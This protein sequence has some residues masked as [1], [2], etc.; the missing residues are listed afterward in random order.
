MGKSWLTTLGGVL[1]AAGASLILSEDHIVRV[2]GQILSVVGPLL[3][4]WAAKQYNVTGGSIPQPTPPGVAVQSDL[5]GVVA[6]V[7]AM[8]KPSYDELRLKKMAKEILAEPPP[9]PAA[10]MSKQ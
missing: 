6:A 10:V 1:T 2:I 9:T 7:D 8:P 4:G 5:L 3:L